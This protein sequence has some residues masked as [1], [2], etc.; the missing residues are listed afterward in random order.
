VE[1]NIIQDGDLLAQFHAFPL[2]I[3]SAPLFSELIYKGIIVKIE[4]ELYLAIHKIDTIL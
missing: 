2:Q 4:K 1:N 3:S